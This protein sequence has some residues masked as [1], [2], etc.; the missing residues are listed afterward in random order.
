MHA[1]REQST[2]DDVL[3]GAGVEMHGLRI[4]L[5]GERLDGVGGDQHRPGL[6]DLS[7]GEILV[8]AHRQCSRH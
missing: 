1:G 5:R 6:D 2:D 7:D 4:E 8:T 3:R